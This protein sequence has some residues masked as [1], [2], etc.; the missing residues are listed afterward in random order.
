MKATTNRDPISL[1]PKPPNTLAHV[2]FETFGIG[3]FAVRPQKC[4]PKTAMDDVGD[5]RPGYYQDI[6]RI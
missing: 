2:V 6:T 4:E 3:V 5:T 1:V